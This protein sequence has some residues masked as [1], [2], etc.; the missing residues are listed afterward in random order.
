M[1]RNLDAIFAS[2]NG[3]VAGWYAVDF[4]HSLANYHSQAEAITQKIYSS[5][6]TINPEIIQQ[7]NELISQ[8]ASKPDYVNGIFAVLAGVV[9]IGLMTKVVNKK[10]YE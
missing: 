5:A 6:Q 2:V 7:T 4:V 1:S 8:V 3:A 9:S 10:N